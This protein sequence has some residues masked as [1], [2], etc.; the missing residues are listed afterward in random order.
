[1]TDALT[2]HVD[3]LCRRA[4]PAVRA[5]AGLSSD[6]KRKALMDVASAIEAD[7]NAIIAAN[8][9][10]V[11]QGKTDKLADAMIDRLR[12]D[13]KGLAALVKDVR[14]VAELPDPVG[15]ILEERPIAQGVKMQKITVPIGVVAIIFESR[16]NVTADAASLCLRSGNACILRGGKEAVH[17]NRAL[18]A[19]FRA[20]LEKSGVNPDAVQLV[21]EQD[22]KLVE[23]L[24]RRDDAID[25]VIPR[26]GESLIASVVACSKVPV[27][28]HDKG[29]CSL[30]VHAKADLDMAMNLVV[31]AKCQ[32]P[33]GCNAIENLLVDA[34]I[35]PAFL[36]KLGAEMK[37][38]QV[39]L[40]V[41][42]AAKK[43][44]PDAKDATEADWTTEYLALILA[45]KTVAGPDEA[46]AFTTD[47][48]SH[49]SDG[50]V[51]AD[52]AVAER[53]LRSVDSAC[54]YHNASTRFTDGSQFGLGAE[55]GISTNR[56]HARGPMGLN[57]LCTYKFVLRGAGQVRD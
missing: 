32:R 30:Y 23:I 50:I 39:E 46:I 7:A 37:T 1:M 26:G 9:K 12:L 27:I 16:P 5:L 41:D 53:Y 10:D 43:F 49:H 31:N 33:G 36:P 17:S 25:L 38:R 2:Q 34:A 54:V 19:A 4:R 18:A 42:A 22:R 13:Q 52:T 29:V 14:A 24:L 35:A 57:E 55:V 28:K 8:N 15:K 40:R 44:L 48:G 21:M 3:D 20:G 56:V 11:A 45:V 51:T 6:A 47:F